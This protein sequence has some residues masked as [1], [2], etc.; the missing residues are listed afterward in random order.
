[1]DAAM[2]TLLTSCLGAPQ[3]GHHRQAHRPGQE[4]QVDDQADETKQV[5]RP[6][7]L[8]PVAAPSCCQ[9]APKIFFP[10]A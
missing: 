8:G 1:M 5:P 10:A 6:T 4:R 3:P 7:P 2:S 9:A